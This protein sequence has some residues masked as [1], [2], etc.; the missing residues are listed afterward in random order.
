MTQENADRTIASVNTLE[1]IS[2]IRSLSSAQHNTTHS[3]Q[4]THTHRT[5]R[6]PLLSCFTYTAPTGGGT[7]VGLEALRYPPSAKRLRAL[8]VRGHSPELG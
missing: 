3:H 1:I 2:Q 5:Q 6:F 4:S 7:G 8:A